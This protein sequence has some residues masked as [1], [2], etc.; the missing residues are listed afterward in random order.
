LCREEKVDEKRFLSYQK[1]FRGDVTGLLNECQGK[2]HSISFKTE[3]KVS[4]S[5][6]KRNF[7]HAL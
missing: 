4:P 2:E 1:T 6:L 5:L 7:T 3:L